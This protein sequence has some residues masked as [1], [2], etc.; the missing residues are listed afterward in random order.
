MLV[1]SVA[2]G[3]E[4]T[5]AVSTAAEAEH[6]AE[7]LELERGMTLADVGAGDGRWAELLA[8]H[9]G[10]EGHVFATEI[11]EDEIGQ[12][13][14]RI[15]EKGLRKVSAVRGSP[16]DTGLADGCCDVML[17]QGVYHHITQPEEM[18][19]SMHRALRPGGRVAVIDFSPRSYLEPV[20]GVPHR[21]GHGISPADLIREM[22]SSGFEVVARYD[23]WPSHGGRDDV[24]CI[25]FL[26]PQTP[27][28]VPVP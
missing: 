24:Y 21:G 20:E 19:A 28:A 1:A 6:I 22:Q 3:C 25:V 23:R 18:R 2:A 26:R 8:R 7:V 9:V 10:E 11:G 4:Q 14:A 15:Q 13:R 17:L 27:T 5:T 12:I 16:V